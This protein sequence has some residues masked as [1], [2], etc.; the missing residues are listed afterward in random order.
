MHY[1]VTRQCDLTISCRRWTWCHQWWQAQWIGF[2]PR[3]GWRMYQVVR[4]LHR[5][6]CSLSPCSYKTTIMYF[7]PLFLRTRTRRLSWGDVAAGKWIVFVFTKRR[8]W[9]MK[10]EPWNNCR[11]L[12]Y[13]G[14]PW[15]SV[16]APSSLHGGGQ[17]LLEIFHKWTRC[18]MKKRRR[19]MVGWR[20]TTLKYHLTMNVNLFQTIQRRT[21]LGFQQPQ[22]IFH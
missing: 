8:L 9:T 7:L 21:L 2:F 11:F 14:A 1:W 20:P 18:C 17:A 10:Q 13:T 19:Q 5:I 22:N 12:P 15:R 6:L 16:W 4:K 3:S